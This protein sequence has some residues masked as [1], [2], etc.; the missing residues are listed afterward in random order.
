MNQI[1]FDHVRGIRIAAANEKRID[2][3]VATADAIKYNRHTY[4]NYN[5]NVKITITIKI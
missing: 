2:D 5:A 3:V 4:D 1:Q